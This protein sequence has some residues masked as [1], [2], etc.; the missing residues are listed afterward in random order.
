MA[1]LRFVFVV[2]LAGD[3]IC[4]CLQRAVR[5]ACGL[6]DDGDGLGRQ[7]RSDHHGQNGEGLHS[8]LLKRKMVGF[9]IAQD[10]NG[11]GLS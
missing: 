3:G 8:T 4:N 2:N 1:P 6:I 10:P 7:S 11:V 5:S 9:R